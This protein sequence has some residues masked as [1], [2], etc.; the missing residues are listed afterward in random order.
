[1][2][3][4]TDAAAQSV[5]VKPQALK[6]VQQIILDEYFEPTMG[7][8]IRVALAL[9]A[10]LVWG[11]A[12]GH[13]QPAVWIA[14]TA[15]VLSSVSLRG[16]YPLKLLVQSGAVPA[17]AVCAA[18]GTLLGAHWIFASLVMMA[19]AFLGG[20]VRQ[21][22]DHGPGITIAVLLLYLLTLDSPG[23][24][25]AAVEMFF[26][27]IEGG[28][29][30][31]LS[32]LVAWAFVPFSPFRRSIAMTWKTLAEWLRA[33]SDQFE[34]PEEEKSVTILDEKELSLREQ[35]TDSMETLSREQAIAHSRSNRYSFQLVEL[36]RLVSE[37][38]NGV[39]ALRTLMDP[40]GKDSR[41]PG[42]LFYFVLENFRQVAYRT[43]VSIVTH[44]PEDV[45]TVRISLEKVKHAIP[46]FIDGL[47]KEG[48]TELAESIQPVVENIAGCFSE[49]LSIME[50]SLGKRGRMTFF[51]HNFFTGMTIPQRIPWV[52]FE[53]NSRSFSFR[54]S[55]RLALGMGVGIAIYK[56]FHI[57]HGYWI[58]M[59]VMIVLQP[60]F[61]A[62]MTKVFDRIKGTVLGA[63]IGSLIFLI[64]LPLVVNILLVTLCAFM[65][66]YYVVRNYGIAAF[67]ITV[68]VIALFHLLEPVTWTLGGIRVLN[69]A[70]GCGF[71][72]LA[73]YAFWPLWERYRFPVLMGEAVRGN[74]EYLAVILGVLKEG[75]KRTFSYFIKSRREAEITNNNAFLSLKRMESEPEHE[76]ANLEQYY[77]IVG[78]S[79][80]IT[81]L[82]NTINQQIRILPKS[83]PSFSAE[84]FNQCIAGV[85]DRMERQL[86]DQP[87]IETEPALN[88][89]DLMREIQNALRADGLS[90]HSSAPTGLE[91]IF[92]MMERI[93]KEVISMYYATLQV[94]GRSNAEI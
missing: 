71:A 59:T 20:F 58:A 4:K 26:W 54:Y 84:S 19:L 29:L 62:T 60:E 46:I 88:M 44:K 23:S 36:R 39:S 45:Y 63:L 33:F 77:I 68:M 27:V 35:L 48:L 41:F 15:Q 1:M 76:R 87:S 91:I 74:R 34:N 49:A 72:L 52:R 61:G 78:C 75:K 93:S 2:P 92:D 85:F 13:M 47:K 53:F 86:K 37:A 40:W 89:N 8:G 64:P 66:T 21:S 65:M 42:K 43:A 70:G 51:I 5:S 18:L 83:A 55:L 69:T 57:P 73:G 81:R 82:L 79:I 94:M 32:T 9:V 22:G 50:T 14:I 28:V 30:A 80:R 7:K 38:G 25:H 17:C 10:P 90:P 11:M 3:L 12:T 16:A 67:F 56:L 24:W 6:S 31:L